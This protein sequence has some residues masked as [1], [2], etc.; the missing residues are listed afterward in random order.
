[1]FRTVLFASVACTLA[2]GCAALTYSG[3]PMV[4]FERHI[5][6]EYDRM[7]DIYAM[8]E[9]K[10][11]ILFV[12]PDTDPPELYLYEPHT[13]SAQRLRSAS[14][15]AGVDQITYADGSFEVWYDGKA[16]V[17]IITGRAKGGGVVTQDLVP[18]ASGG[19]A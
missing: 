6:H 11:K 10:T 17:R 19:G 3:D 12:A 5:S 14:E 9:E 1:M 16:L 2:V 15:L 8:N 7:P 13:N 4:P 18:M